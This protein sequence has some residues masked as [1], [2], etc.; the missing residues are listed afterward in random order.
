MSYL[1]KHLYFFLF[2]KRVNRKK[3]IIIDQLKKKIGILV[4]YDYTKHCR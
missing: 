4:K 1:M 3:L 2:L